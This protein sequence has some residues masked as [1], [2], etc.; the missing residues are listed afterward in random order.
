MS[1]IEVSDL[2]FCY[3]GSADPV[4]E[5]A[6]FSI[7]T[8]WRLGFVGRNGRG[9]TTF[10]RLLLGGYEYAGSIVSSV[11]FDY[12]PFEVN[13]TG[14]AM[15]EAKACIA[16]YAAWENRMEALLADGSAE[17][18]HEYG[19]VLEQ[20]LAADGYTIESTLE[21]EAGK[22]NLPAELLQRPYATL[23]HGERTR[24]LLA[25]LFCRKNSFLLID[26]P[27]NH[28]DAE[29]RVRVAEYLRGK[30]G[31]LLVS[32]DRDLLDTA[33]DHVLSINKRNIEVMRGNYSAWKAQKDRRDAESR[34][35]NE[36]LKRDIVKLTAAARR[37]AGWADST[38][39]EKAAGKLPDEAVGDRGFIGHKAAK[40]MKRSKN[41]ERRREEA[42]DEKRDLLKN[43]EQADELKISPAVYHSRL[44]AEASGLCIRY[45]E[46]PRL[47]APLSFTVES[48]ERVALVGP[49]G[50]GKSSILRLLLGQDVPHTGT[51]RLAGGVKLSFVP[52]DTSALRGDLREYAQALG[53][54]ES[55]FKAILRKLDFSRAQ[56]E[57]DISE[58]SG[59]QKKKV[60]LAGSLCERAHLYVWDE[61]LNFVDILSRSQIEDLLLR[62]APT[63]LFVEHDAR[64]LRTV[65]TKTVLLQRE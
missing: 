28:L 23:S 65:A 39:K 12:F 5:H 62:G 29:G 40:M 21:Q 14:T 26:E 25:A 11:E 31:F 57:K 7:D 43:I 51:L 46:A 36:R 8:D 50:C 54:D 22:L 3:E 16:P 61:P 27:T 4:F 59:G 47:F 35:E 56:F 33:V 37:A 53:L 42:A 1:L 30:K 58:Y 24:L 48:G 15:E 52:Q 55:L 19:A 49:N 9:K 44:L 41:I 2:T 13:G 64:F 17:A 60:L 20:Y 63:M 10:C 38:E 18:L 34:A 6:S 45:G 32:H